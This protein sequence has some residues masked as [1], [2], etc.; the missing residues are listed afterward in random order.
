[1]QKF[2]IIFLLYFLTWYPS[3]YYLDRESK[4]FLLL[5][6]FN[7][8]SSSATQ[9]QFPCAWLFPK[10]SLFTLPP[11]VFG[12]TCF[13]HILTLGSVNWLLVLLNM[14]FLIIQRYIKDIDA[15]RLTFSDTLC[16]LML[17]SLKANPTLHPF[18]VNI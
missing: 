9:N 1:M 6:D 7:C 18:M 14:S 5:H 16:L 8:M 12:R 2:S 13:V 15:S 11:R 4:S 10:S 17:L 3:F